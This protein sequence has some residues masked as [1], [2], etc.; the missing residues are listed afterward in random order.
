MHVTIKSYLF[1]WPCLWKNSKQ[2]YDKFVNHWQSPK[3][4]CQWI[5]V[6]LICICYMYSSLRKQPT[7][8]H[9][10][11]TSPLVSLQNNVWETSAE[12]PYWRRI[13]KQTWVVLLIISWS[14]FLVSYEKIMIIK[15]QTNFLS[16]HYLSLPISVGQ[17]LIALFPFLNKA[18]EQYKATALGSMAQFFSDITRSLN[19]T[20]SNEEGW[21]RQGLQLFNIATQWYHYLNCSWTQGVVCIKSRSFL[22]YLIA[23]AIP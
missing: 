18:R 10:T 15:T 2:Y 16:F 4:L 3:I 8:H 13:L 21:R 12:I 17:K 11:V 1:I 9:V 20:P 5:I 23:T 6:S 22:L 7:F 14:K 19:L